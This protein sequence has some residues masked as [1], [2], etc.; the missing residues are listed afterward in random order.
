MRVVVTGAAGRLGRKVVEILQNAGHQT[1][2]VDISPSPAPGHVVADILNPTVAPDLMRGADAL[3]HTAGR[4]GCHGEDGEQTYVENLNMAYRAFSAAAQ[5]GVKK[6]ILASSIQVIGWGADPARSIWG[7]T[8]EYLP[9]DDHYPRRPGSLYALNK[10]ALEDLLEFYARTGAFDAVSLRLPRLM[11]ESD[12]AAWQ[13]KMLR[14][15]SFWIVMSY[16]SAARLAVA[17]L[18]ASLPGY[19]AYLAADEDAGPPGGRTVFLQK[20]YPHLLPA[21]DAFVDSSR[22]TRET[23]WLPARW[24]R[25]DPLPQ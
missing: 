12:F 22:A 24:P 21:P 3:I 16:R 11:E 2:G 6:V 25:E 23:G 4:L 17:S 19:R 9:L 7:F 15:E 13:E 10:C 20:H 1:S 5:A 14:D 8:P 18:E